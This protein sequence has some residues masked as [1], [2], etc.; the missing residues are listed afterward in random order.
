MPTVTSKTV[1][2]NVGGCINA[3]ISTSGYTDYRWDV[4][5]STEPS[6]ANLGVVR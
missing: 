1:Y 4:N 5:A 3:A 2:S 6:A